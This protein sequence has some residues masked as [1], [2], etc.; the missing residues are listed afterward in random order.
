MIKEIKPQTNACT[1][2]HSRSGRWLLTVILL[3]A[4][5]GGPLL[6]SFGFQEDTESNRNWA[7]RNHPMTE[8][9][10]V[11]LFCT[12][13]LAVTSLHDFEDVQVLIA[14]VFQTFSFERVLVLLE[15]S[16]KSS[17]ACENAIGVV[18]LLQ[19][20]QWTEDFRNQQMDSGL[21]MTQDDL[22]RFLKSYLKGMSE[23]FTRFELAAKNGSKDA[24]IN[25]HLMVEVFNRINDSNPSWNGSILDE[26]LKTDEAHLPIVKQELRKIVLQVMNHLKNQE[27]IQTGFRTLIN[28]GYWPALEAELRNYYSQNVALPEL[29]KL[30]LRL[31]ESS[32]ADEIALLV[33]AGALTQ[34]AQEVGKKPMSKI[35]SI[36]QNGSRKGLWNAFWLEAE[37]HRLNQDN[38]NYKLAIERGAQVGEPMCLLRHGEACFVVQDY[39]KSHIFL[40]QAFEKGIIEATCYLGWMSEQGLGTAPDFSKALEFYQTGYNNQIPECAE[41]IGQLYL[42]GTLKAAV[43]Q[44]DYQIEGLPQLPEPNPIEKQNMANLA[45]AQVYLEKASEF[46]LAKGDEHQAKLLSE[47]VSKLRHLHET[48]AFAPTARA[49]GEWDLEKEDFLLERR[50]E[51]MIELRD[52]DRREVEK[53]NEMLNRDVP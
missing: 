1:E 30:A 36:T 43:M 47:T 41:R 50:F 32:E 46:Y 39:G 24:T 40:S 15:G 17:A 4:V 35:L 3:T 29:E 31:S 44:L 42:M 9:Q 6:E 11:K 13:R 7:S 21:G 53:R 20:L 27:E 26:Q 45:S 12:S 8:E 16:A 19:V 38:K 5:F 37:F 10:V 51:R 18:K 33:A 14:N 25:L 48:L 49:Y 2:S 23:C 52:Q 22:D 34:A 28:E